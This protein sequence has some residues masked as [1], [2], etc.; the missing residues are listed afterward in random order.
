M[1]KDKMLEH[2]RQVQWES[3]ATKAKPE[4]QPPLPVA[5]LAAAPTPSTPA[6]TV[7]QTMTC[8]MQK[9][10]RNG[11]G[12]AD[13]CQPMPFCVSPLSIALH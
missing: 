3:P 7:A 9:D 10:G 1:S 13:R 4:F 5:A 12:D 6:R 8:T 11:C 2:Y